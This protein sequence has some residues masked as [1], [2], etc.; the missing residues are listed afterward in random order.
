MDAKSALEVFV[1]PKSICKCGHLGDG[2]PS[3]HEDSQITKG[4]G[5]CRILGCS[6]ERFSW[7]RFTQSFTEVIDK[8]KGKANED[9]TVE[10]HR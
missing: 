7:K 1:G 8:I 6:C 5:R 2:Y 10:N 3:D 9:N 4:H